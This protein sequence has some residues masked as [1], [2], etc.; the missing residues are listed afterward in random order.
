MCVVCGKPRSPIS[1]VP[2]GI[3][4]KPTVMGGTVARVFGWV[5]LAGGLLFAMVVAMIIGFFSGAWAAVFGL[6]IA[7]IAAIASY[8][9]LKSGKQLQEKGQRRSLEVNRQA[10]AT[11]AARDQGVVTPASAARALNISEQRAEEILTELVREQSDVRLEVDDDGRL[12]YLFGGAA[13]P[14]RVRIAPSAGA[15]HDIGHLDTEF[16]A[17]EE[18]ASGAPEQRTR[19]A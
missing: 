3:A 9:I 2:I 6:M 15:A 19:R 8:F 16:E 10:L 4:G 1:G 5:V 18:A 12:L 17:E 7:T 11:I 13:P 14:R